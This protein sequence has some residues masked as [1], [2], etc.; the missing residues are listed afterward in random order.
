M[1][2]SDADVY[3][4][5]RA[6]GKCMRKGPPLCVCVCV[7]ELNSRRRGGGVAHTMFVWKVIHSMGIARHIND[8]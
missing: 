3:L 8:I 1:N 4:R 6:G 5:R 7:I 2:C